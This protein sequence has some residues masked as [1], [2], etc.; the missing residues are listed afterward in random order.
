MSND[1]KENEED[2][3]DDDDDEE[4]DKEEPSPDEKPKPVIETIKRD[5]K[6]L[7]LCPYKTA[8]GC[9]FHT[10]KINAL[11][12]HIQFRH[13]ARGEFLT[14]TG[15]LLRKEPVILPKRQRIHPIRKK[16]DWTKEIKEAKKMP[17]DDDNEQ[18]APLDMGRKSELK[19]KLRQ[20]L[21][22]IATA[23]AD[24]RDALMP[25]REVLMDY[26]KTLAK[27][28]VSE[29]EMTEIQ[30]RYD[31]T[32]LP[33]VQ[34]VIGKVAVDKITVGDTSQSPSLSNNMSTLSRIAKLRGKT[35]QY[36][37]NIAK[38][39]PSKR[40]ELMAE[41]ESLIMLNKR[42]TVTN[43]PALEL[44]EMEEL[45][46][47]EVRPNVDAAIQTSK[48]IPIL[49]KDGNEN[50]DSMG[51]HLSQKKE[52]LEMARMDRMLAEEEV[53]RK[54]SLDAMRSNSN[55]GA[56]TLAPVMRPIIDDKTGQIKRDD[57]G[58]P[59]METAYVPVE[60]GQ[61]SNNLLMTL[62][63]SGKM[64]GNDQN[65]I[66]AVI[67]DNNT[68]LLTAMLGNNNN[69]GPS[70]EETILKVQNENMKF[71]MEMQNKTMELFK[72][73]G[74]DPGQIALREEIRASRLEQVQT[75][76]MMYKQQLDYMNKEMD[77]L[78]RYAYRDDLETLQ[79]QKERLESLGIVSSVQKDAESKA[80]EE[81]AK[82]AK[83]AIDKADKIIENTQN[84][85]QPFAN[86]QAE[87]MKAQ[88]NYQRPLH[89]AMNE[90][91][92]TS[93]YRKILKN[94][95]AEEEEPPENEE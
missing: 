15:Q 13:E 11:S 87:L 93:T 5:G 76:D 7:H 3:E 53:R 71:M 52:E 46:E 4:E 22:A 66:L 49:D 60:Q 21:K 34:K 25:E 67:M 90:Q 74:D 23:D 85:I 64:G 83:T 69:K 80:L 29:N 72:N 65:Q 62:L 58:N 55:S 1:E 86:A 54:Q 31:D 88:I 70:S 95:E 10:E 47:T 44:D 20:L 82:L 63:L 38:L 33:T 77:D 40:E 57:K 16:S 43:I 30:S 92:K 42:L 94:I 61:N 50:S 84:L 91:E 39:T 89:K 81:S 8:T 45:L 9:K 41:R 36:L 37:T 79:K 75:R 78:K 19:G 12:G 2:A 73:K 68:K 59:I 48:K 6:V 56:G 18:T 28:N 24:K 32:L 14:A 17:Y 27:A 51:S 26:I 35:K